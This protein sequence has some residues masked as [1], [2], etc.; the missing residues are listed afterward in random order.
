MSDELLTNTS[1][2]D[3]IEPTAARE[4]SLDEKG[5]QDRELALK[6]RGQEHVISFDREKWLAQKE[7]QERELALKERER[8]RLDEELRFK[9]DEAR[10]SRWSNP[11]VIAILTAAAAAIGNAGVAWQNGKA[12]RELESD[13]AAAALKT[14]QT[15]AQSQLT[16]EQFKAEAARI[17]EVVKT[18]DPDRAADGLQFLIHTGLINN[19]NLQSGLVSYLSSRKSGQGFALPAPAP[20]L[21]EPTKMPPEAEEL[22]NRFQLRKDVDALVEPFR[23]D[24]IRFLSA[25][26][27]GGATITIAKTFQPP[28]EAY[29]THYAWLIAHGEMDPH[30]V[31]PM[32]GV[33]ITWVRMGK[34][35]N[36]DAELSRNYAKK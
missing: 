33:D 21:K 1:N 31:P 8:K 20:F 15:N 12:Q 3:S 29:L 34:D 11:L 19:S 30:T 14:Q 27:K 36:F 23:S 9:R 25:L 28:E 32:K 5:L 10:R 17:F 2:R 18:N 4:R 7:C 13:R 22:F 24:V 35:D 26:N 16:V 6:E